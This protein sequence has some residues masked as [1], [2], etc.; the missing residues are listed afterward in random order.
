[1]RPF[2]HSQNHICTFVNEG[3]LPVHD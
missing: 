1:M 2:L 3:I